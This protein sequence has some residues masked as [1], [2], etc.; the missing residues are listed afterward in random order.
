[1]VFFDIPFLAF[2][3]AEVSQGLRGEGVAFS[4]SVLDPVN[5]LSRL[6]LLSPPDESWQP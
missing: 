1:M 2:I 6:E 4:G 3:L 5:G